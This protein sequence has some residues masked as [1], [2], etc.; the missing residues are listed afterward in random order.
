MVDINPK[1]PEKI[2][3]LLTDP[4]EE[5]LKF[6]NEILLEEAKQEVQ[7][8]EPAAVEAAYGVIL[9]KYS[10]EK[11]IIEYLEKVGIDE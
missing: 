11:K 5:L 7:L 9:D 10:R 6:F 3:K 1:I 8:K 4:P 2:K